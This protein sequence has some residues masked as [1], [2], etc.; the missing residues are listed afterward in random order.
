MSYIKDQK[1]KIN[2]CYSISMYTRQF[3]LPAF[4]IRGGGKLLAKSGGK[5]LSK[6]GG[7]LVKG[8]TSQTASALSMGIG[9]AGSTLGLASG[10]KGLSDKQQFSVVY[11]TPDGPKHKSVKAK[12][13]MDAISSVKSSVGNISQARAF[14]LPDQ[15]DQSQ[16]YFESLNNKSMSTVIN[17]YFDTETRQFSTT[18]K[19]TKEHKGYGRD[20]RNE[21]REFIQ[22]KKALGW[23]DE[24]IKRDCL[25]KFKRNG[26][27]FTALDALI[28]GHTGHMV[29]GKHK[30]T[31]AAIGAA[32][33]AGVG[34]G[35][36]RLDK[37][38]FK[39]AYKYVSEH[40]DYE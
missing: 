4:L 9:I 1:S 3:A 25:R 33:G 29:S 11:N 36:Y 38:D 8:L 14:R 13:P 24:Q 6:G 5:I 16:Q 28:A 37:R 15:D 20:K 32:I 39:N 26:M 2:H 17:I 21:L 34:Y 31:G 23:T 7:K 12:S 19:R 27:K 18:G 22:K 35:A 10:L 40:P 30:K